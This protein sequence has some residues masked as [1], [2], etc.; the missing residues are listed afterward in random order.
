MTTSATAID[1]LPLSPSPSLQPLADA[2]IIR[3]AQETHP[4]LPPSFLSPSS[5]PTILSY[6]HSRAASPSPSDAVSEYVLSILSLISLSPHTPSVAT[7]LS[8]LLSSYISLQIP[9]DANSL[10]AVH[11][12]SSLLHYVPVRDIQSTAHQIIERISTFVTLDDCQI[13]DLLPRAFDLVLKSEEIEDVRDFVNFSVDE[14]LEREWS[15]GVLVKMVSLVREFGVAI[16]KVRGRALLEKVF[17]GIRSVD[18]QDL[19]SLVYQLLVLASKGFNKREVIEGIVMLFGSELESKKVGSMMRQVEGTVLLHV[20]FAVKQDPSLGKEVMGLVKA[21]LRAF[22]HFT[23][24]VLL[25]IARVRRFSENSMGVLRTTLLMAYRDYSFAK[26]CKWLTDELKEEHLQN[27]KIVEKAVLRAVNESNYGREHIVPS[28]VQFGF[29]LLESV[30][31]GNCGETLHSNGLLGIEE[32]G[33]QIVKNLFEVHDMVRNEIIEQC[34]FRILSLKPEQS[35]PVIRLLGH[36]VQSYPYILLEYVSRIKE[37]LDYYTFMPGKVAAYL[38]TVLLPLIK[39]SHDLQ[40]YIILVVRKA[41]FRREDTVRLAATNTIINLLLTEFQSKRDVS[42]SFQDSSSQASSSQQTEI[43]CRIG[44][45]LF[46]ELSGLLQRCLYQQA[47][48]KE[49]MYYGLVKIVLADPSSCRAVFDFLLPHFLRF[50]QEDMDQLNIR[51]C[52]KTEC[53]KVVLEEPLDCL[54][55]CISWI[56][57]LQP[58]GKTDRS[59]DSSWTCFGFS[60]SQDNE[61]GRTAS[62]EFLSHALLKIRKFLRNGNVEEILGQAP[63]ACSASFEEERRK[64][65]ASVSSGIVEV[66]LN[67]LAAETAK[68]TVLKKVELEKELLEFV[69]LHDSLDKETRKLRQNTGVKRL[70]QQTVTHGTMDDID[71]EYRQLMQGRFPF[72]STSSIHQL[73][74]TALRLCNPESSHNDSTSQNRSQSSSCRTSKCS[75]IISFALNAAVHLIKSFPSVGREDPLKTLIYGEIEMLGPPLLKLIFLLKSGLKTSTDQKKR[76][77][78]KEAEDMKDYLH[79]GLLCLKELVTI[80]LLRP[81]SIGLI[82]NLLC[83]SLE[84]VGMDGEREAVSGIDD[85]HTRRKELLINVILKPLVTELLAVSFFREAEVICDM[86]LLIK[87]TLPDKCGPS[88]GDWA[89]GICKNNDIKNSK[90]ARSVVSLAIILS[91]P[92]DDFIVAK[93]MAKELLKITG[94]ERSSQ[95]EASVAYPLINQS[96]STATSSCILQLVEAVLGDMEWVIKKL[97]MFSLVAQKSI[98]FNQNGE[99]ASR[100]ALEENLYSRAEALVE[101]LSSFVLMSLKD[102]QAEHLLRLAARFYKLLA[103]MSRLRIA[104][105]GFKQHIPSL[106]F[107]KLVELTC[108]KLTVPLYNFVAEMQKVR[109]ENASKKGIINKIKRENKC[110]P[111]LIFQIEDYEKYLIRLSK[112]TKLNFLRHAKRSTS[113]D[114]RIIDPK[115]NAISEG[116]AS[117]HEP[118]SNN[119]SAGAAVDESCEDSE[120]DEEDGLENVHSSHSQ[121]PEVSESDT[122]NGGAV[123]NAKRLKRSRVVQDSD[124][125][126]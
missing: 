117:N 40:D 79:L 33:I 125:E 84:Y 52:V 13:L 115:K 118:S 32:I 92:P 124:D 59:S 50:F 121:G 109:Q 14:I 30:E 8:S 123:P 68:A 28:I 75:K 25:S 61:A 107:Q 51:S 77:G 19:P 11:L 53:R 17:K 1:Q 57:L 3:L 36:L 126:A 71:T 6:L 45:G 63:D 98:N 106:T 91:S 114:F 112:L 101:V 97:K 24:A 94:P 81:Q 37:L 119:D 21:D 29:I 120:K 2:E 39:F 5:H 110:I 88:H 4:H 12:F 42:L 18:L 69:I 23:V 90:V 16:D 93:D 67:I 103:Q 43:P 62:G 111:D 56:L 70:H 122:E 31:E 38:V 85:Q 89:I 105:K 65:C 95:Q 54:L 116:D 10:K 47:K 104:P 55:S 46:Q 78:R 26:E 58:Q 83:V 44:K 100:L 20:N 86:L 108:K 102:N 9:R 35:K 64:C 49:A 41:M 34:K 74:Q 87:K 7:L 113:R 66:V 76:E 72:L 96:T 15:K 99:H 80:S 60:L 73:L 27:V 48:V 22:N 82:D